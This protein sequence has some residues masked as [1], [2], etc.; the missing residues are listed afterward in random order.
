MGQEWSNFKEIIAIIQAYDN[1]EKQ[2]L[3]VR[4]E[5]MY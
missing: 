2:L 1:D 3:L 4:N 5:R